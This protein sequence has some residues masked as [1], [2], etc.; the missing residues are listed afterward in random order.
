VVLPDG[1]PTVVYVPCV[2]HVTDPS[3]VLAE[4]YLTTDGRRV[5]HVYS[6]L[7]R[8]QIAHGADQPWFLAPAQSLSKLWPEGVFDDVVLDAPAA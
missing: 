5:L 3:A 8:L 2:E 1:L 4:Y 7:D 6:D